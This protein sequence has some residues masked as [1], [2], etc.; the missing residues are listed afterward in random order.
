MFN[1]KQ[2]FDSANMMFAMKKA[3]L[4]EGTGRHIR[5]RIARAQAKRAARGK[6]PYQP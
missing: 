6:T 3:R 1:L 5:A 2:L 4:R